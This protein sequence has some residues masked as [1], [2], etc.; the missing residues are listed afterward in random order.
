MSTLVKLLAAALLLASI[1][2]STTASAQAASA[3]QPA[4]LFCSW[5]TMQYIDFDYYQEM[6]KAGYR[7][8]FLDAWSDFSL[9]KI[10]GYN[11]IVLFGFPT[12]GKQE[13][14]PWGSAAPGWNYEQTIDAV[15]QYLALGGGV[16]IDI[17][18]LHP[19][20][21]A[22]DNTYNM[23]ES[24]EAGLAEFGAQVPYELFDVPKSEVTPN[25]HLGGIPYFYTSAVFPS[26]V[27]DGVKGL[28]LPNFRDGHGAL[29]CGPVVVDKNWTPVVRAGDTVG[30]VASPIVGSDTFPPNTVIPGLIQRKESEK[31][32]VFF[33]T[34]EVG[35]GRMALFNLRPMFH[36]GG[37][38]KWFYDRITIE[39]GFNGKPS[40]FGRLLMNTMTW[41]SAPS[42]AGTELGGADI[43]DDR[44][45]PDA[46]RP[47]TKAKY[48]IGESSLGMPKP[49]APDASVSKIKPVFRG[50][51]GAKTA[52]TGGTGSFA[53]Y[54]AAA[55]AAHVDFVVFDED[56]TKLDATKLA[57]MQSECQQASDGDVLLI[58]GFSMATNVGPRLL[59]YG[60]KLLLPTGA[61][62]LS[63][64]Q[65]GAFALQ[66]EDDKGAFIP[67]SFALDFLLGLLK[68]P[69]SGQTNACFYDFGSSKEDG[70]FRYMQCR[71][72]GAGGVL[73]Y[74][75]GKLVENLRQ[76]YLQTNA[77]TMTSLPLVI[78]EVNSPAEMT[79]HVQSGKP[80]TYVECSS[81]ANL[82][83]ESFHWNSQFESERVVASEGPTIRGWSES[84]RVGMYGAEDF[85][86]ERALI[87]PELTAHSDAGIKEVRIY[88][89]TELYRRFLPGGAK[90]FAIRLYLSAVLQMTLGVEVEDVN[91]KI[92]TAFPYRCHKTDKL[93][94]SFCG[95]HVNDCGGSASIVKM[96][97]GPFWPHAYS[98]AYM[99]DPGL[100][101]DGGPPSVV[102]ILPFGSAVT[103]VQTDTATQSG[104]PV[105]NPTLEF[106]DERAVRCG[107]QA[108]G[109]V[110]SGGNPWRGWGP[111]S[112]LPVAD[113]DMRISVF[114]QPNTG[115]DASRLG[116]NARQ[117]G[118][119]ST[120]YEEN[121][122][123]KNDGK[124]ISF[125][126]SQSSTLKI[127]VVGG[128]FV[129]GLGDKILGTASLDFDSATKDSA[130]EI[131]TGAWFAAIAPAG[132]NNILAFNRGAPLRFQ[133]TR[134]AIALQASVPDGGRAVKKGDQLHV[135]LFTTMWPMEN[136]FDTTDELLQTLR[137]IRDP[138]GLE[139][140]RGK[141]ISGDGGLQE[142]TATDGVV[143]VRLPQQTPEMK[144]APTNLSLRASGYNRNWSA[145]EF[146]LEG[147]NGANYYSQGKGVYRP[148]GVDV[149]GRIYAPLYAARGAV[150]T[151]LGHPITADAAGHDLK[152]QVTAL[153]SPRDGK[154]G[155]WHVSVNNPTDQ[156]ITS[157][158]QRQ[159]DLPGLR[160]QTSQITL[161]PG[162]YRILEHG[163][164][165]AAQL[166]HASYPRS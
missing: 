64:S 94:V 132:A 102:E 51:I 159:I 2:L 152:I 37:G 137:Y 149:E 155:S 39:R 131:P 63:K 142:L 123:F 106:A 56:W 70:R 121:F 14:S 17:D 16:I 41:A 99:P 124:L 18:C 47:E 114:R 158:L 160:F 122:T 100:T 7:V 75:D 92:A 76:E 9:E 55:K 95:D 165:D 52:L 151:I 42:L 40:D 98:N 25:R 116:D 53:D 3:K 163:D 125:V 87:T 49:P 38:T 11:A 157:V 57:T 109:L 135:E 19:K 104:E 86:N 127:P 88:N 13:R 32:A 79:D 117:E 43:P 6:K 150:H 84:Q 115:V 153:Q 139:V 91:G 110:L 72:Y 143:E 74:R 78:S 31:N 128:T 46:L 23:M 148:V 10:K 82:L 144:V 166:E 34:R 15:K 44:L 101:W 154:P 141:R 8:D 66:S 108:T 161:K 54:A 71:S 5:N 60:S 68:P 30:T 62:L 96:A 164:I 20:D 138:Q 50:F 4:V 81:L 33:A 45:I 48:G 12:K 85:V 93:Y 97:H 21:P 65:P 58:P 120:L 69:Y 22:T 73:F 83:P 80:L 140:L 105:Q 126:Q 26:P 24:T 90:D 77:S 59:L 118:N 130:L 61:K 129:V 27:S 89:G 107:A 133:F 145:G 28:W 162:E 67:E 136:S 119:A 112:L 103:T 29:Y 1:N 35:P 146:Q 36:V 156:P 111:I 147:Y 113:A 134:A